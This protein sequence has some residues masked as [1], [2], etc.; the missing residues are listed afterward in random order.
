MLIL[1]NFRTTGWE[2]GAGIEPRTSQARP[3]PSQLTTRPPRGLKV[4]PS[5]SCQFP[6]PLRRQWLRV[7]ID[8]L[9]CESSLARLNTLITEVWAAI[10]LSGKH[11]WSPGPSVLI[12]GSM[13]CMLVIP[14]SQSIDLNWIG[15]FEIKLFSE[16][17]EVL[18]YKF[19]KVC[20]TI[21]QK[22]KMS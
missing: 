5:E 10:A 3:E 20:T 18:K 9:L 12:G 16:S 2:L 21:R 4:F 15:S 6:G 1:N 8:T 22:N 14:R 17:S 11:L 7:V 13:V 19:L